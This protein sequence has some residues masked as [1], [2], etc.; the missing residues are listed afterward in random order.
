MTASAQ[1]GG[2]AATWAGWAVTGVS[3]LTSKLIRNAPAGSE[4]LPADNSQAPQPTAGSVTTSTASKGMKQG[5]YNM[6]S[7]GNGMKMIR[8]WK[9]EQYDISIAMP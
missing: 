5:V 6:T 2:S 8:I 9:K 1:A 3:S 7:K 4:A